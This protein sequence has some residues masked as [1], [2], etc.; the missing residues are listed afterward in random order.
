MPARELSPNECSS[1]SGAH[2]SRDGDLPLI[3]RASALLCGRDGSADTACCADLPLG[4]CHNVATVVSS[5]NDD[6]PFAGLF[7]G[8]YWARTSGPQLVDSE[9]RSLRFAGV[10]SRR[11][12]ERTS[13]ASERFSERERTPSVAIVA[14][15]R[16]ASAVR[17]GTSSIGRPDANDAP[18]FAIEDPGE[19]AS[20][21]HPAGIAQTKSGCNPIRRRVDAQEQ[22]AQRRNPDRAEAGC[23]MLRDARN[24]DHGRHAGGPHVDTRHLGLV[25]GA[26]D[27]DG[28]A[29]G[30]HSTAGR[31][32]FGDSLDAAVPVCVD[33]HDRARVRIRD[34]DHARRVGK[35]NPAANQAESDGMTGL[36]EWN[37]VRLTERRKLARMT[38]L[39]AKIR[40]WLGMGKKA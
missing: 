38:S 21:R 36:R 4:C 9:R 7:Y 31:S 14:T 6:C 13:R 35:L 11:M 40:K 32:C 24:V 22:A 28:A 15:R 8:R 5:G 12:V 17:N 19:A 2:A 20:R 25:A 37:A 23:D 3:V 34:P 16:E 27:P 30:G 1:V 29:E 33:P 39:M 10:R 26:C 18:V